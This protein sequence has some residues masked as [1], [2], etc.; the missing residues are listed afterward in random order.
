MGQAKRCPGGEWNDIYLLHAQQHLTGVVRQHLKEP[1]IVAAFRIEPDVVLVHLDLPQPVDSRVHGRVLVI[2]HRVAGVRHAIL[3]SGR[4]QALDLGRVQPRL[5][6]LLRARAGPHDA[7][8]RVPQVRRVR[9]DAEVLGRDDLDHRPTTHGALHKLRVTLR[10]RGDIHPLGAHQLNLIRRNARQVAAG[11]VLDLL[12]RHL[13]DARLQRKRVMAIVVDQ[14]DA[15]VLLHHDMDNRAGFLL[16][17]RLVFR[18]DRIERCD[19]LAARENLQEV[20]HD[21]VDCLGNSRIVDR[22]SPREVRDA[23][24][25]A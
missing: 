19:I 3:G 15:R 7:I 9:R 12:P 6:Q 2:L 1:H 10:I 5:H 8:H 17:Q 11:Q 13:E 21:R 23:A 24:I 22:A 25:P 14:L 16:R 18:P 4:R 20:R